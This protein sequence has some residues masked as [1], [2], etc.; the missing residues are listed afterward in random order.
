M[1]QLSEDSFAFGGPLMS[2][3]DAVAVLSA[4]VQP[5]RDF[6]TVE[7]G[8]ADGRISAAEICAPLPLPPWVLP[9]PQTWAR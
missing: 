3:N 7:L 5:V 9:K 6:E 4:R 2:V 8:N 1:A